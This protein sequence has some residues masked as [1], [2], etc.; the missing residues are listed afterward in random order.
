MKACT[1]APGAA[2]PNAPFSSATKPSSE[3][4]AE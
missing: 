1:S 2:Q 4:I 3:A